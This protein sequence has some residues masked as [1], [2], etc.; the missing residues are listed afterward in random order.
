MTPSRGL[1]TLGGGAVNITPGL[2]PVNRHPEASPWA[3]VPLMIKEERAEGGKVHSAA[4]L[5]ASDAFQKSE[6]EGRDESSSRALL[7]RPL[8]DA[9]RQ[10]D[11]H[12]ASGTC[13]CRSVRSDGSRA[14]VVT[15]W[16]SSDVMFALPGGA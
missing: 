8:W 7:G 12:E 15:A 10:A 9:S 3:S 4:R 6:R 14:S 13:G 2:A 11:P 1:E 5:W 16:L